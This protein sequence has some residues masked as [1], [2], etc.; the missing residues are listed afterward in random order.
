MGDLNGRTK[1][2]D[3]FVRDRSDKHSPINTPLYKKDTE[4]MRNNMDGHPIDKQGKLILDLCKSTG[5]KILNGRM[6]GD[7]KGQFTRFPLHK[8]TDKPS[9]ID[10]ALCGPSL[11]NEVFSFSVLPFTELS[12]H[13]C[14]SVTIKVNRE[15]VSCDESDSEV[16]VNPDRESYTFD[17][18]RIDIFKENIR[19]DGNIET[20][21]TL[22]NT[23]DQTQEEVFESVTCLNDILLSAA[24]KSFLPKKTVKQNI[25]KA[26]EK[27]NYGL[28]KNA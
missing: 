22:M 9:T 16:T 15:Q 21:N 4:L 8:N 20:L 11:M 23:I 26:R 13:C 18:N 10:Y 7:S 27:T 25:K 2:G 6:T 5:L 17:Q 24:K 1:T 3:D 12:D 14:I 19:T 28:T